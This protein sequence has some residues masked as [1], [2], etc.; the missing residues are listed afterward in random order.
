MEGVRFS[1]YL[2]VNLHEYIALLLNE[3]K[4]KWEYTAGVHINTNVVVFVTRSG[5]CGP[6]NARPKE[7]QLYILLLYT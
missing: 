3:S 7:K 4:G 2:D 5:S 6:R 1:Q